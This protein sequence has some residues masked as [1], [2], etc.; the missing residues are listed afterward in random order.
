[1]GALRMNFSRL[2]LLIGRSLF[3]GL[4]G[5]RYRTCFFQLSKM[6]SAKPKQRLLATLSGMTFVS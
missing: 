3:F 1:M 6:D 4:S 5:D 2:R